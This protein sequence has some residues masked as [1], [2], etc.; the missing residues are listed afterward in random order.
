[1]DY[2]SQNTAMDYSPSGSM[3]ESSEFSANSG[4]ANI[5]INIRI[6]IS[7]LLE[8]IKNIPQVSVSVVSLHEFDLNI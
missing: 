8:F 7:L 6:F 1:M 4:K 5:G 2:S 3:D